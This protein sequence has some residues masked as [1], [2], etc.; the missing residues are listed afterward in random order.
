MGIYALYEWINWSYKKDY[1]PGYEFHIEGLI[2]MLH[3]LG[4]FHNSTS[5]HGL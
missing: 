2:G 4:R 5:P 3:S 1:G